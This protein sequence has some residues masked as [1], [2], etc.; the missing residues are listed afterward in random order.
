VPSGYQGDTEVR[1]SAGGASASAIFTVLTPTPSPSPS[2]AGVWR[3]APNTTWQWQLTTPVDQTVDAQMYDIDLFDNDATV[4]AALEAQG[5]AAV[6]YLSAGTWESWRPDANLFPDSV[7]GRSN[8]WAG[9]KWL[10]VRQISLLA[11]IMEGRLDL[12]KSKG[13]DA[14]EP[15]NVDGYTNKTGFPLT[16]TDQ[17]A[18]NRWIADAAHARGLSVGLK[19][20]VAQIAMLE[21]WFDWALDEQCFQ[22][23]ECSL[24]SPFTG[25]GK[26]VFEVEYKLSTADFC[27]QA[28]ALGFMAMKKNLSLDASRTPCW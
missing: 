19:N 15:D 10:D 21:P 4:V 16:A 8:G 1:V 20:D 2:P 3:P 7:I 25:A 6:C 5:R 24:L 26:A 18:Y 28:R 12:C 17:L 13:F 11:P 23:G 9:E 14:V 22:Y 27:P